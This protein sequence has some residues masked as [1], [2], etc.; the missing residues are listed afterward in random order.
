[1]KEKRLDFEIMRILA[2]FGVV[3]NH[4][5]ERGFELYMLPECSTV[6]YVLS[7]I[8]AILCK[9]AVPLFLLVSGGL[10]LR[11]EEP[12][13]TVLKKRVL[14]IGLVLVLFSAILYGFWVAWGYAPDPSVRD[15]LRRL[16]SEGI[17]A[18]YWYLYAYLGL[19]LLLPLLR[20]MVQ[21]MTDQAFR[22]L[23]VVHI[24]VFGLLY[25]LACLFGLGEVTRSL[26]LSPAEPVLFY[27]I[28]GYY[29]A[30]RFSWERVT[31]RTLLGLT[32]LSIAA[33][34]IQFGLT[35][36]CLGR[37]DGFMPDFLLG[38]TVVP[39][40]TIY[41]AVR[42]F[43]ERH[44]FSPRARKIIEL[45]GS[46]TFGTYLMEGIL[47][48]HLGFVFE[49]LSPR[50]HVLPACGIWILLVVCCGMGLTWILKK[51]PGFRQLL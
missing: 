49:A 31:G 5:Q 46:C 19:M 42:V 37:Q 40:F 38:F 29:F 45:L 7:L 47:R 3:F 35:G 41:A 9:T 25:S 32:G 33:V 1:M 50:I 21:N 27:F 22:Y 43:C 14:R 11:R 39:V 18:P 17:S 44:S 10:L 34:A 4:S 48:H 36:I 16:W 12:L 51:L 13:G 20:P 24:T 28:M 26:E 30:C 8:P 6:N 23:A 2:I 15:F